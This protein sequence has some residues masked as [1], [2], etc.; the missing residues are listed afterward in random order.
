VAVWALLIKSKQKNLFCNNNHGPQ[1]CSNS[2]SLQGTVPVLNVFPIVPLI[3]KSPTAIAIH[4]PFMA[5][6]HITIALGIWRGSN[7]GKRVT[8]L[9]WKPSPL[10]LYHGG[11][12]LPGSNP[13]I[14]DR[15]GGLG[16]MGIWIGGSLSAPSLHTPN[17]SEDGPPSS[18]CSMQPEFSLLL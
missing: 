18:V 6:P 8:R 7:L 14:L 9:G 12:R 13:N 10:P 16:G 5:E 1:P 17:L 2:P 15:G 3:Q 11:N 4:L